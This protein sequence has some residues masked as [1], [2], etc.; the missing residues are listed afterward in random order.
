MHFTQ[1]FPAFVYD[2]EI[3]RLDP[4][5]D[6]RCL[7]GPQLD[8]LAGRGGLRE[9]A[10]VQTL[11]L[12]LAGPRGRDC[13]APEVEHEEPAPDLQRLR[14]DVV[15]DQLPQLLDVGDAGAAVA[16]AVGRSSGE[17]DV[18]VADLTVGDGGDR[19]VTSS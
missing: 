19:R 9:L 14:K 18:V 12:D 11:E 3:R 17:P 13:G 5:L 1:T 8:D 7:A 4:D 6:L 10:L 2:R 16:A 15:L